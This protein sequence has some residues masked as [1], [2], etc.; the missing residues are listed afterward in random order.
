MLGHLAT[1]G[2]GGREVR[3]TGA[4]GLLILNS[5]SAE[6]GTQM[7]LTTL[8]CSGR[9]RRWGDG[10]WRADGLVALGVTADIARPTQI[11]R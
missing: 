1:R 4:L 11:G 8:D 6:F 3:E 7:R 2:F 5:M 9:R 10:S